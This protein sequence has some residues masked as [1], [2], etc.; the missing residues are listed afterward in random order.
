MAEEAWVLLKQLSFV[1]AIPTLFVPTDIMVIRHIRAI[2]T[3]TRESKMTC[4]AAWFF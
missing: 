3:I 2:G 4:K 1:K